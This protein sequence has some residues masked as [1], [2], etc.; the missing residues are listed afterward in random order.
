[1][2]YIMLSRQ[3]L[4]TSYNKSL[5]Y[6]IYFLGNWDQYECFFL[7]KTEVFLDK[8]LIADMNRSSSFKAIYC[9]RPIT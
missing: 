4:D 7:I 6:F 1:M 8:K 9:H 3:F 5:I 2:E